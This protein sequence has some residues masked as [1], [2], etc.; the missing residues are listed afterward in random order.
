MP[1]GIENLDSPWRLCVFVKSAVKKMAI[2]F[3]K[4]SILPGFGLSLGYA[5]TY[6]SLIVLIPLAGTFLKAS[7]LTW[8]EFLHIVTGPR[9]LASYRLTFGASLA[10]AL[11]NLF[12][13]VLVA[14][15]LVR[16]KF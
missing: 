1:S 3:K 14:W 15:V 8:H 2:T 4:S 10:A 7:T 16:Y 5:L 6:L 13:G 9:A 12:F 11:I